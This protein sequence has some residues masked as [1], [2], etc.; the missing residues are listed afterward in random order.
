VGWIDGRADS[1]HRARPLT[2]S[3]KRAEAIRRSRIIRA[4]GSTEYSIA[5]ASS[6]IS[7]RF[8]SMHGRQKQSYSTYDWATG[9]VSS[10]RRPQKPT[11]ATAN[12][13][14]TH[15]HATRLRT[16]RWI[17]LFVFVPY[18][19]VLLRA[20]RS[21]ATC[22]LRRSARAGRGPRDGSAAAGPRARTPPDGAGDAS[23][24]RHPGGLARRFAIGGQRGRW[25]ACA[26]VRGPEADGIGWRCC[27]GAPARARDPR[28]L[29]SATTSTEH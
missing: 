11:T 23:R 24:T 17:R 27:C 14:K 25:P 2:H 26:H 6:S 10:G 29:L 5:V 18:S 9:P 28:R 12:G 4:L 13:A 15:R 3:Y 20:G 8:Q 19:G 1:H 21:A 22:W 7:G 16:R